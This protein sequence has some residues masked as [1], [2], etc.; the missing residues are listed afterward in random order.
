MLSTIAPITGTNQVGKMNK[1]KTLPQFIAEQTGY[2][3]SMVK[4]VRS[5]RRNN[6]L[7]NRAF[8]ITNHHMELAAKEI[9]EEKLKMA[10]AGKKVR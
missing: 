1:T 7:I 8:E 6:E 9:Q 5:K 10:L 3:P 4:H 2:K